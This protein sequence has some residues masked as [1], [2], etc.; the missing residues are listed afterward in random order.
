MT[1]HKCSD[2]D[3]VLENGLVSG[4]HQWKS[5]DKWAGN[6][7][8]IKKKNAFRKRKY[9]KGAPLLRAADNPFIGK[10]LW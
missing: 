3:R 6:L 7:G 1:L 5:C 2:S 4:R 10:S 8:D 9:R